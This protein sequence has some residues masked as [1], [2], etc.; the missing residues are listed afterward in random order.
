[1]LLNISKQGKLLK[2]EKSLKRQQRKLSRKTLGS[3]NYKKQKLIVQRLYRRIKNIK[4]DYKRKSVLRIVQQNPKFITIEKLNIK[5]MMKD[6]K[7][8]NAFQQVGLYYVVNWLKQK[9]I[10]YDVEL[11]QVDMYY[12]SSQICSN[13]G[14]KKKMPLKERVYKCSNCEE[15]I[16]RD[17]NAAINLKQAKEFTLLVI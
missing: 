8:S 4:N 2:L 13:C 9:C 16:D 14:F 11:R 7:V 5:E 15:S 10:E 1:M 12:P 17:L 3:A 6:R